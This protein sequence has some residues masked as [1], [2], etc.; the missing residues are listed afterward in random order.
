V[1]FDNAIVLRKYDISYFECRTCGF[2]Q[3]EEPYWL[4]E[5]YSDTIG[6]SDIGLLNRNLINLE[7]TTTV[8]A[9]FLNRKGKFLDYG[10][11][12]GLFVRL[13]R[14]KGFDFY[15]YEPNC[16]NMFAKAFDIELPT[17]TRFDMLTAFEVFEHLKDPLTEIEQML[18]LSSNIFFSTTL[19]PHPSPRPSQWWY[20]SLEGGQHIS[21]Y[22]RASLSYLAQR[23]GVNVYSDGRSYHLFTKKKISP[24]IYALATRLRIARVFNQFVRQPSLLS[25]D[26]LKVVG[27]P[28]E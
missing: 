2:I 8:L 9:L 6:L 25:E 15:L 19:L 22:T 13:M 1:P 3:T 4:A 27:R 26:Y 17:N 5:A 24:S 14:D 10:G 12:Y 16:E 23:M 18:K 11:G 21:L 7:L 28:L 20:Y